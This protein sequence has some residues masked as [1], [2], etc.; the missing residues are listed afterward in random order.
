MSV[1]KIVKAFCNV[2]LMYSFINCKHFTIYASNHLRY[3]I[4]ST[5]W[6]F[7]F[8]S[9]FTISVIEF[10]HFITGGG[11]L[12]F[13]CYIGLSYFFGGQNFEIYYFLGFGTFSTFF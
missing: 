12:T 6:L 7:I 10:G 2:F 1:F 4:N 8:V 11:S 9:N 13:T 3:Y 5:I